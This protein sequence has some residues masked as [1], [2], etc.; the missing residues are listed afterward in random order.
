MDKMI[1]PVCGMTVDPATHPPTCVHEGKTYYFC[2]LACQK[3]FQIHPSH[4]LSGNRESME[5]IS[6]GI[7]TK[8]KLAKGTKYICPMCPGIESDVPGACPKCGMALEPLAPQLD[9]GP[10]PELIGM[11]RRLIGGLILGLPVILLAMLDMLPSQPITTSIG[12]KTSLILQALLSSLVVFGVGRVFFIRAWVSFQ[13][14]ST[15]M[16]TLIVLGVSAAYLFSLV[17]TL[18]T[19][20]NLPLFPSEIAS[21]HGMVEPYFE[22]A[23]AIVLLVLLGQV[24]ELHARRQTGNAIRSLLELTPRTARLVLPD[25]REEEVPIELVQAG[26]RVRIRPGER[27]TVDGLIREGR[28]SLD[29]SM[30]TGEPIPVTKGPGEKVSAGTI[31]G[32]GSLIVETQQTGT[33]T[34]LA[35]IV[36]LVSEAQRSRLPMQNL[37]DRVSAWFVPAVLI[38]SAITFIIW[39][40]FASSPNRLLLGL[41]NSV[42]VL[43]IACPCALGLA[44]PMA[45]IV[46]MGRA[47]RKG[48]LF[49][50]A[51]SIQKLAE[52]D[53]F[54]FDKTGTLTEGKP[55]VTKFEHQAPFS[56][57]EVLRL[58]ASLEKSS[59]HPFAHAIITAAEKEKIA[60]APARE[61][62]IIPGKGIA[63]IVEDRPVVVGRWSFLVDR[64]IIDEPSRR[65][66][67]ERQEGNQSVLLIGIDGHF[68]GL[69]SVSDPLRSST[70]EAIQLLKKQ[71]LQVVMLTGDNRVTAESVAGHL[72]IEEVI[73]EVLPT[74]K[75]E[76][77]RK[78][79]AQG[80]QVAMVGD[81]I[82]D[83]PALAQAQVGIALGTGSDLAK[84]AGGVTLV[85]PDLRLVSE[86]RRLSRATLKTIRENLLLAFLYNVL[87][88]PVAAGV[89]T[90]FGG[91]LISPIWAAAAMSLSSVS[92]IGN[93]LR[94]R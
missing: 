32:A 20:L 72:G 89:L 31:N 42:A 61:V 12:W 2:A 73:A 35:Q 24:L 39:A 94:L 47:A 78:I 77:I 63:G 11:Q 21:H 85:R 91:G 74:E 41:V 84:A 75:H 23:V 30:L 36:S 44:T 37:V 87:A 82:N 34:L 92:V 48:I 1:D 4:Y 59:E 29:E 66:L 62:E 16:F 56:P 46:G 26:D 88:I 19:L 10:D 9:S 50:S 14:R 18:D 71:G 55:T 43:V 68:A 7:G 86:S 25:G 58:A 27:V 17:V 22:S 5:S 33:D 51:D 69:L 90:L 65:E 52:I 38:C 28:S 53:T 6:L 60:L 70:P 79:Q 83:G 8:A 54:V 76:Q 49:R 81:G 57:E 15:N 64:G 93:S 3:K 45:V 67:Q 40:L 80:R 13:Q